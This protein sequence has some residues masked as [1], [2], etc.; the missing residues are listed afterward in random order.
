[1]TKEPSEQHHVATDIAIDAGVLKRCETHNDAVF[2]ST[3]DINEAF[4]LGN[5]LF[6]KGKLGNAFTF[7][8]DM[9]IAISD[10]VKEYPQECPEC[11]KI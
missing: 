1:M 5:E 10:V 9:T 4:V 3:V 2:N 11:A 8:R 6:S 7:R